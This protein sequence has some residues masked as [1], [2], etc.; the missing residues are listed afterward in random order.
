MLVTEISGKPVKIVNLLA[1]GDTNTKLAKNGDKYL[2]VGFSMLPWF[3][4]GLGN[5]CAFASPACIAGCLN[6]TGLGAVFSNIQ[7]ARLA[8]R[9]LFAQ[10]NKATLARLN[11]ELTNA[12]KRAAKIGKTV[13]ARLNVFSDIPWENTGIIDGHPEIMF[14]DYS[15]SPK[16]HGLIRPNYWVTFSRSETNESDMLKVLESGHN[17]AV[18][19]HNHGK[20]TGNRAGL[21]QLPQTYLGYTVIDGDKTDLRFDDLRAEPGKPG[22]IIGLKLKASNNAKRQ[23]AIDSGFSVLATL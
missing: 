10:Q 14:Y 8:R 18:V 1:K 2:T 16:R 19:F 13:A 5:V 20:F 7:K 21:Q 4:A 22:Y 17:V 23:A 9:Q 12:T 6:V 15:K 3:I 11:R